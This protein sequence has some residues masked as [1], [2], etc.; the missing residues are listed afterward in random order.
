MVVHGP[1]DRLAERLVVVDFGRVHHD[2]GSWHGPLLPI[3]NRF[4]LLACRL[5]ADC[6][7]RTSDRRAAHSQPPSFGIIGVPTRTCP[8]GWLLGRVVHVVVVPP[9]VR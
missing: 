6:L 9:L 2:C 7:P 5:F 4:T 3:V 8:E 1:A